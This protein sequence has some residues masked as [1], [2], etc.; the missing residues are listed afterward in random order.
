MCVLASSGQPAMGRGAGGSELRAPPALCIA[1]YHAAAA[2]MGVVC[3]PAD[4]GVPAS[5]LLLPGAKPS[6][7]ARAIPSP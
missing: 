6:P 4:L 5:V 7:P 1:Q 2:I 3:L